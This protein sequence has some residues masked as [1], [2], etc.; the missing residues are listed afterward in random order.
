MISRSGTLTYGSPIITGLKKTSDIAVGLN[1]YGKGIHVGS[2]VL[3]V[4]SATQITMNFKCMMQGSQLLNI[5]SASPDALWDRISGQ[6]DIKEMVDE[7]GESIK[8]ISRTESDVTRDKYNSIKKRAQ[9]TIFFLKAYP[10]IFNPTSKQLEKAGIKEKC[11]VMIYT[12]YLDWSQNDIEFEDIE[13][14]G[15][16]TIMIRANEYEIREKNVEVQL[17]DSFGY[18]TLALSRK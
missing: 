10:V 8:V 1:V 13:I 6:A 4:D 17:I 14:N 3:S 12:A 2:T 7:R 5:T 11:D 18:V 15:R 9:H 16:T